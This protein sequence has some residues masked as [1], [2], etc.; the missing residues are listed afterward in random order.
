MADTHLLT[1]TL[2]YALYSAHPLPDLAA[3]LGLQLAAD[4]CVFIGRHLPTGNI[5]LTL[6]RTQTLAQVWQL[7]PGLPPN[8][9]TAQLA[10]KL[11]REACRAAEAEWQ[12]TLEQVFGLGDNGDWLGAMRSHH[13]VPIRASAETEGIVLLLSRE[14][15]PGRT[16]LPAL[17]EEI[18]ALVALAFHQHHLH[19]Q[20]HQNLEQLRYLNQLKDDFLSTLN[21]ELR[22]PL[23]SMMLAIRMLRRPDLTPERKAMYLDILEQQC[24]RET[25]LVNDLLALQAIE[26]GSAQIA[27]STL[28]LNHFLRSLVA[29]QQLSFD[30]ANLSLTLELPQQWL[31]LETEASSLSR[32]FQELLSNALK[33][34]E[35]GTT[36]TLSADYRLAEAPEAV[37][38]RLQSEGAGIEPEELPH[39]FDKFRRGRGVTQRAIPGTG[40]G[41]ALVKGLVQQLHGQISVTS[42]PAAPKNYWK[43][44]F[45]ICLPH[46][47]S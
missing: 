16:L 14:A 35:P 38:I 2:T 26:S 46:H 17:A 41:L 45:T 25:T 32:I 8:L 4:A 37:I 13:I 42:Q 6:W 5:T 21:H 7:C 33:Y 10:L 20:T 39:I 18:G 28:N 43:T 47:A 1:R 12:Q 40:T 22:T 23:T 44:C 34:A 19:Q 31:T 30:Q 15:H 29:A 3:G 24:A 27:L 11:I 9:E 36:V